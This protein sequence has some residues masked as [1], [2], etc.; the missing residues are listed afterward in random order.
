MHMYLQDKDH[1]L[2]RNKFPR[3]YLST[4]EHIWNKK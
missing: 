1:S 3:S 4:G 2:G